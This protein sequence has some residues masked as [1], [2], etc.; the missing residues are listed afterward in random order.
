MWLNEHHALSKWRSFISSLNQLENQEEHDKEFFFHRKKIRTNSLSPQRMNSFSTM[1]RPMS[2]NIP[3]YC[4]ITEPVTPESSPPP[5]PN[6]PPDTWFQTNELTPPQSHLDLLQIE[7]LSL[8]NL[9]LTPPNSPR[10]EMPEEE[11]PELIV[12]EADFL[13]ENS[14][15]T[16]CYCNNNV[17]NCSINSLN[18]EPCASTETVGSSQNANTMQRLGSTTNGRSFFPEWSLWPENDV[19]PSEAEKAWAEIY[20]NLRCYCGMNAYHSRCHCVAFHNPRGDLVYHLGKGG[21]IIP[22]QKNRRGNNWRI[23]CNCGSDLKRN[24][25]CE[26]FYHSDDGTALFQRNRVTGQIV[27]ILP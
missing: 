26:F 2:L 10:E 1:T 16:A 20:W 15:N 22:S 27:S 21:K 11:L 14:I 25:E 24:C 7:K 18:P 6:T 23:K 9:I 8:N 19:V 4:P 5:W 12:T 17:C 13:D 3:S